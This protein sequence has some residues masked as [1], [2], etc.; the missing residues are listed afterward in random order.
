MAAAKAVHRL[1]C[2]GIR[3]VFKT[4]DEIICVTNQIR[5]SSQTWFHSQLCTRLCEVWSKL[6]AKLLG[7]YQYY[8]V[9][10][11]W[12]ALMVFREE[13]LRFAKRW[14]NRRRLGVVSVGLC[15]PEHR[16]K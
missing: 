5:L 13:V 7:H 10:D 14:L 1:E 2:P 16:L 3:F 15:W 8:G 11:N 4:A 6:N 12:D 9:T